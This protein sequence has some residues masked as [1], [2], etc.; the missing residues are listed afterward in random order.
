M[1]QSRRVN[2]RFRLGL[3]G[4]CLPLAS[5]RSHEQKI[6]PPAHRDFLEAFRT[7]DAVRIGI[8]A[9]ASFDARNG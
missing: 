5:G 7:E 8:R 2:A 4:A 3:T 1:S 6:L 9:S